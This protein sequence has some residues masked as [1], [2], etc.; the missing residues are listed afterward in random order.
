MLRNAAL[1]SAFGLAAADLPVHCLKHEVLGEWII[2]HD[3]LSHERSACGHHA[4]DLEGQQPA[5]SLECGD[6]C[7]TLSVFLDA[8]DI[9]KDEHGGAIGKFTM[10]YDEGI[11][12]KLE[13]RYNLDLLAF[14]RYE[15]SQPSNLA[16]NTSLCE[17]TGKGWVQSLFRGPGTSTAD[18]KHGCFIAQKKNAQ[19]VGTYF[20][21]CVLV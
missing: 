20:Q 19:E 18:I 5:R 6:N 12:I 13:G 8:P 15:L 10:I 17:F 3:P 11:Q 14:S 7:E 9:V 1:F 4:P 21:I 2:K 16:T